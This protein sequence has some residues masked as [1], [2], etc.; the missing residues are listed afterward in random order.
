M[1]KITLHKDFLKKE[2][3]LPYEAIKDD[4]IDQ[5]RWTTVHE[6]IFAYN[7]KFWKTSYSVGSTEYQDESPWE[8]NGEVECIEVELIKK[9]MLVWETK[10]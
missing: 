10:K 1:N 7:D 3:D 2:L 4:I 5:T 6:I 8:Y 9:E